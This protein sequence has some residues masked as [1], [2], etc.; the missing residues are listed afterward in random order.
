MWFCFFLF[1]AEAGLGVARGSGGLGI[2]YKRQ[3]I[4]SI[5]MIILMVRMIILVVRMIILGVGWGD[6]I[7]R[8]VT[9]YLS[10]YRNHE[11]RL[12]KSFP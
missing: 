11:N 2:V 3:G 10:V 7:Y 6:T 9:I 8:S 1:Q 4:S 5:R 12:S